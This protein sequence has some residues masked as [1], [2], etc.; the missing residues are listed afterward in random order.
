MIALN[1]LPFWIACF[2]A[3]LIVVPIRSASVRQAVMA[4]VNLAFLALLLQWRAIG[5]A[6]GI[7]AAYFLIQMVSRPRARGLFAA[8]TAV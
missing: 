4:V 2:A 8:V 6:G 1:T 3:I 5:L 7:V